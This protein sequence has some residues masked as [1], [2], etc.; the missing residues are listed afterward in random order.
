MA[1]HP[2]GALDL[3]FIAHVRPNDNGS[4]KVHYVEEHLRGVAA[5]AANFA[6]AFGSGDWARSAGLW[7]DLGKYHPEFQHYI[8]SASGYDAGA[9]LEGTPGRVD[10]STLGAVY[11]LQRMGEVG[12]ILAYVIA[13]H[14]AGLPDYEA[15]GEGG[16]TLVQ[17]M[18]RNRT[19]LADV[20]A[21]PL[22]SDVLVP[23]SPSTRP[24]R[25]S[26]ALWIRMLFSCLVDA[27]F[28]DTEAFMDPERAQERGGHPEFAELRARFDAFMHAKAAEVGTRGPLSTVN[29]ARA[30]V[31]RQCRERAAL[32]PGLFSLSVPTGGG[33][34]LSSLA[35]ALE[36]AHRHGK[37]RIIYVIP[38]TSI[39]EQT[40]DVFR[41]A[42]SDEAVVEHHS[43]LEPEQETPRSRLAAENWDAP[44]VVTTGVQFWESLFA[45]HTS[46]AR[47]LHR[48]A[49]SV[50]VL[51]EA[52]TLPPEFLFP[53]LDV[54]RDLQASYGVSFLLC[55]ATQP[56]LEERG[57]FDWHFRGLT[58]VREIVD[59]PDSLHRTL[60][61]VELEVPADLRT[62]VTWKELASELAQEHAVLCIVNRRDDARDL[63]RLL[64]PQSRVHLSALMCGKHRSRTLRRIRRCLR[65]G[66][67][68]H[69]VSTQL[70][71]AGVDLDFPV[72]YRALAGLDS[73]AQAAG[74]C[75]REGRL[76]RGRVV[77]FVP[78]RPAPAGLL[79]QAAD[80]GRQ[81]L[82][83]R[84]ADPL[85]P[86]RFRAYFEDL[87]WKQG[88][89][90][91]RYGILALLDHQQQLKIRFRTAAEKFRLIPDAQ[92]PVVVRYRNHTLLERLWFLKQRGWELDR[93][94]RRRLQR[95]VVGIPRHLHQQLA[96]SGKIDEWLPG[97]WVQTF[98]SMYDP[99]LGLLSEDPDL[100]EAADLIA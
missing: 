74:R 1:P 19:R 94:L 60:K 98:E 75:N 4:F 14:H 97:V 84:T 58:G 28:L 88:P 26:P 64:P 13:G 96:T 90:L 59:D 47:K 87:Y 68:I 38:Y 82:E 31:L 71:E 25:G 21:Q 16:S 7:H 65:A 85:A 37:R 79:R 91:D 77:V 56:A 67:R 54:M 78:P 27:D 89:R 43:N 41:A 34:T 48:I 10:H 33:K 42:L 35:W 63:F 11:A 30:E 66:Q 86:A 99:E 2:D 61:R 22:P 100:H 29:R 93:Q 8:A 12:R 92:L 76:E 5:L 20:L 72:V 32:P 50:V 17:R 81:S 45:A 46:R 51:D 44:L 6:D 52:Q 9:H 62:P 36:H 3:G 95:F 24:P 55:T 18:E 15:A 73:V 70:V 23:A 49:N 57:G 39:I 80:G 69:V 40:A 83:E 53:I